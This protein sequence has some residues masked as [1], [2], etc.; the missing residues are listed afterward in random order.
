MSN[1]QLRADREAPGAFA[2]PHVRWRRPGT[3][4]VC[5]ACDVLGAQRR[6]VDDTLCDTSPQYLCVPCYQVLHYDLS[7]KLV[8]GRPFKVFPFKG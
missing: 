7:G 3:L 5:A 2:Y 8:K 6:L 1:A 4:R